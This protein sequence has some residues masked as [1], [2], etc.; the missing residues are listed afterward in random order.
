MPDNADFEIDIKKCLGK[1][2]KLLRMSHG[3]SRAEMAEIFHFSEDAIAKWEQGSRTPQLETLVKIARFYNVDIDDLINEIPEP[4][5]LNEHDIH[6]MRSCSDINKPLSRLSFRHR[7]VF[8]A[9]ALFIIISLAMFRSYFHNQS[10]LKTSQNDTA[11]LFVPTDDVMFLP[12]NEYSN[13]IIISE[14]AASKPT[15]CPDSSGIIGFYSEEKN[16]YDK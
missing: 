2:L 9:A 6:F 15:I 11:G 8:L 14:N 12:V 1:N 3:L 10:S 7:I 16:L 4:Y 13:Q 5:K